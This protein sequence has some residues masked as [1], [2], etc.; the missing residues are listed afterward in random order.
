MFATLIMLFISLS[1]KF[2]V[3]SDKKCTFPLGSGF[4][5]C[6]SSFLFSRWHTASQ[7]SLED[8]HSYKIHPFDELK[9]MQQSDQNL[10]AQHERHLV[11]H[12]AIVDW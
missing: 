7:C 3:C 5:L 4:I 12:C 11:D 9:E 1:E 8:H 10:V 6:H 2:L